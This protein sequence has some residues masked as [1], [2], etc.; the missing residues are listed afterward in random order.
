MEVGGLAPIVFPPI[1]TFPL[2]GGKGMFECPLEC[3]NVVWSDLDSQSVASLGA[4]PERRAQVVYCACRKEGQAMQDDKQA[5]EEQ[6]EA[7][8]QGK[9]P[10]HTPRLKRLGKVEQLTQGDHITRVPD[11]FGAS[12]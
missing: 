1:L 9:S 6:E 7:G 3:A 12:F 5:H 4:V 8:A 10:Y 2:A 11:V